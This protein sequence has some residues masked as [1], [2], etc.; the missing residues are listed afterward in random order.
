M[1]SRKIETARVQLEGNIID[2]TAKALLLEQQFCRCG[3]TNEI[4]RCR[5]IS[6][7][8]PKS[9]ATR[10]RFSD[11][12]QIANYVLWEKGATRLSVPLWFFNRQ[13]SLAV[14]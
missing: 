10:S 11:A 8:I 9:V 5:K 1:R 6:F 13:K 3:I 14:N 4:C 12:K 7:W 2:L